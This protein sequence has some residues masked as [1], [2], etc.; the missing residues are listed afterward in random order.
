MDALT[1]AVLD[2]VA[3][4]FYSLILILI[5]MFVYSRFP[6]KPKTVINGKRNA[7]HK[8]HNMHC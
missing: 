6:S 7:L 1:L 5:F 2:Y 4:Y 3:V 8:S